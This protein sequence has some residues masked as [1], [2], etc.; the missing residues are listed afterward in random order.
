MNKRLT[1]ILPSKREFDCRSLLFYHKESTVISY[2][3]IAERINKTGVR[4]FIDFKNC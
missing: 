2:S 1:D 4:E 3:K